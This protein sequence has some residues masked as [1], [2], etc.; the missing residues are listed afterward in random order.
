MIGEGI[1]VKRYEGADSNP[2]LIEAKGITN[3]PL[4]LQELFDKDFK[5][6]IETK[7]VTFAPRAEDTT[8]INCI[9]LLLSKDDDD[10]AEIMNTRLMKFMFSVIVT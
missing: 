7:D 8:D 9:S 4:G 5:I 1:K 2:W 10:L 6:P 3:R